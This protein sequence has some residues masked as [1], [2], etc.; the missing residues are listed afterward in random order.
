MP[1]ASSASPVVGFVPSPPFLAVIA[2]GI[3]PAA[4]SAGGTGVAG[5]VSLKQVERQR[6]ESSNGAAMRSGSEIQIDPFKS[7][8]KKMQVSTLTAVHRFEDQAQQGGFRGRWVMVTLTYRD[9]LQWSPRH[10]SELLRHMRNWMTRRDAEAN[11]FWVAEMQKRGVIH[12]HILVWLPHRL[13]LPKP[14]KQ[15]WWKHGMSKVEAA[16]CGGGYMSKYVSKGDSA[17]FPKG[18]RIHGCGGLT[19]IHK[20][21]WRWWKRPRYVRLAVPLC[22]VPMKRVPG[23]WLNMDTGELLE[24]EW[25]FCGMKFGK[26]I[27]R[28]KTSLC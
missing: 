23:G 5:L 24:S 7:R 3:V 20:Q 28:L 25:K 27:L 21:S 6:E 19:G 15:G 4:R 14:D 26:A 9:S 22:T 2:G 1:S 12:Y 13:M 11:F 18:A 17:P 16:R 10:V 8:L